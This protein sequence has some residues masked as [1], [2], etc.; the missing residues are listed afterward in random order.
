MNSTS[1]T[2]ITDYKAAWASPFDLCTVNSATGT[3]SA[4][5]KAAGAASGGT[6]PDT[7]KYLYALCATTAGH[8][9]EGEVSAPQAKEIAAALTLCP[10]HPKRSLLEASAAAGGALDADRA[11]GKLVYTGKYLVGKDVVPGTWQSQGEKVENCYWEISDT[12]GNIMAN[13]FISVAPQFTI[14]IP[15]SAAGFTVEGCG[16]RWISG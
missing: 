10:D 1:R 14:T 7:A 3:Q 9:F 15:A 11:N 5:E 12:Q 2:T 8:Y 6:S 4:A 16:F 13:N